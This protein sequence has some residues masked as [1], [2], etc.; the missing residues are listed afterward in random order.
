MATIEERATQLAYQEVWE[1]DSTELHTYIDEEQKKMFVDILTE[2][3]EIDITNA[4]DFYCENFCLA[5]RLAGSCSDETFKE[6]NV[7]RAMRE[8]MI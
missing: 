8:A 5:Y 6:C 3:R 1:K 2:Q 4:Q 7:M